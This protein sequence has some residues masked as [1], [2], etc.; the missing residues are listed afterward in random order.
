M[1]PGK[2]ETKA[3]PLHK[4][5]SQAP[6]RW[7]A[8]SGERREGHSSA[9]TLSRS[10]VVWVPSAWTQVHHRQW[11]GTCSYPPGPPVSTEVKGAA[12]CWPQLLTLELPW[13]W[14]PDSVLGQRLTLETDPTWHFLLP[15]FVT[16]L[17]LSPLK[18][19]Q[20]STG[21]SPWLA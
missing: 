16:H 17:M 7:P 1:E 5:T 9:S 11:S 6:P 13:A 4:L 2:H 19:L 10:W 18:Q 14:D 8:P 20:C 12:L 3:L 15:H 21:P